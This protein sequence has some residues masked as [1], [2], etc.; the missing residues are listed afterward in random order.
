MIL[1]II[2]GILGYWAVGQTI[3]A[4]RIVF[5]SWSAIFLQRIL[6]GGVFGIVLIPWAILKLIFGR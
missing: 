4:N 6:L 3:W 1:L 5:G 2:Y